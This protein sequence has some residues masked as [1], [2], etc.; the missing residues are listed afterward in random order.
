MKGKGSNI[1]LQGKAKRPTPIVAITAWMRDD[2]LLRKAGKSGI[3]EVLTKPVQ[4]STLN[5]CMLQ[6]YFDL[7]PEEIYEPSEY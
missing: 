6:F 7:S 3:C 4:A 1:V 5:K 2:E